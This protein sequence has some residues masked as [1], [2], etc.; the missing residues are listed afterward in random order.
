MVITHTPISDAKAKV[1]RRAPRYVYKQNRS[2]LHKPIAI[3][4]YDSS[5][6]FTGVLEWCETEDE[7]NQILIKMQKDPK[8]KNLKIVN[9]FKGILHKPEGV[10]Y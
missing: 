8:M 5:K 3:T 10:L 4:G 1:T 9:L 2:S 7:A 6:G